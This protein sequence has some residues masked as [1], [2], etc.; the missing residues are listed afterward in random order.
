MI[1]QC[2]LSTSA[3]IVLLAGTL[4]LHGTD[5]TKGKTGNRNRIVIKHL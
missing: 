5:N 1:S 2:L 4:H 3:A